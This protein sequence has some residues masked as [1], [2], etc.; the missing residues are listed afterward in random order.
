VEIIE[1]NG[2]RT[3]IFLK[4]LKMT[5]YLTFLSELPAIKEGLMLIGGSSI[6]AAVA[7]ISKTSIIGRLIDFVAFN[8]LRARN[9][10]VSDEYSR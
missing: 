2:F 9:A 10:E 4:G 7:P 5:E 3:L 1:S 8:W 6:V